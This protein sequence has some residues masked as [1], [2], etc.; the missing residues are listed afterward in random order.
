[1]PAPTPIRD[2]A[3]VAA[4][5]DEARAHGRAA[6]DLEFMWERTYAPVACLAQVATPAAVHLRP[7]RRRALP[8][9]R[10]GG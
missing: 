7:D 6:I 5:V 1:M 10:A 2:A 9:R 3:G 4:V 8:R